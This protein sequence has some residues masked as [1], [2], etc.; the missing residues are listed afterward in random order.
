MFLKILYNNTSDQKNSPLEQTKVS[1]I[2]KDKVRTT[3]KE[4]KFNKFKPTLFWSLA[5]LALL[6]SAEL[7]K[8]LQRKKKRVIDTLQTL[9]S[10][11]LV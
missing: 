11:K 9:M 6:I 1:K 4:N 8:Y 10:L 3:I 5:F 7:R 2:N